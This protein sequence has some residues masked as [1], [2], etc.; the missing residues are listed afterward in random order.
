MNVGIVSHDS[1]EACAP[2]AAALTARISAAGIRSARSL[3]LF[4]VECSGESSHTFTSA[5][6]RSRLLGLPRGRRPS[7]GGFW[8]TIFQ[9]EPNTP[10]GG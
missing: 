9:V 1:A 4:M 10:I 5:L 3:G 7:P 8:A 6:T 2:L